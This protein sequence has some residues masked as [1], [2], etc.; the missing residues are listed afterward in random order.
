MLESS[1]VKFAVAIYALFASIAIFLLWKNA[2][3]NNA[4]QN[5]GILVASILPVLIS[6]LPY[7][8][9]QEKSDRFQ[10]NFII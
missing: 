5:S 10:L 1:F 9:P 8:N 2:A 6:I 3:A 7:I 4:L